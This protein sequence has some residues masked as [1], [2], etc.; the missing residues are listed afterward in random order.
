MSVLSPTTRVIQ[1]NEIGVAPQVA[2]RLLLPDPRTV[3][4]QRARR[5]HYLAE[6]HELAAWLLSCHAL[7]LAQQRVVDGQVAG[8]ALASPALSLELTDDSWRYW[9]AL[10]A[11]CSQ[12]LSA[13]GV[14]P[15][16]PVVQGL[17]AWHQAQW[18]VQAQALLLGDEVLV[19]PEAAPFLAA[20][21]QV[22]WTLLA[23]QLPAEVHAGYQGESALCPVCGSHPMVSLV[24]T[25]DPNHGVRYLVCSLCNSQW[26][27]ARAKCTNCDSPKE[28][29][30]LGQSEKDAIQGECC[31][32]CH[33]YVKLLSLPRDVQLDPFADDLATLALDVMLER[34]GYGRAARNLFLVGGQVG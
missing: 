19:A 2:P 6:G 12:P 28:V 4:Q 11:E 17:Q 16:L 24:H 34:E 8:A 31:D 14:S 20:A 32:A 22:E 5:L 25:G 13:G 7:S 23:S 1:A 27:A 18:Q 33:G 21:L 10:L 30:L 26:H 9:Q 29:A 3:F 15:L